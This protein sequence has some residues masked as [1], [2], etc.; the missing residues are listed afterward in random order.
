MS[1]GE[2]VALPDGCGPVRSPAG[3][4][5]GRLARRAANVAAALAVAAGLWIGLGM[6]E[7]PLRSDNVRGA[8]W[9]WAPAIP[10]SP[11]RAQALTDPVWQFAPWFEFAR[12]ELAAGRV[13]LWNPHQDGGV[14]FLANPMTS[15]ASPLVW[16]ILLLGVDDGWNPSLLARLLL[17]LLGTW[18]WLRESG[19][20][21]PAAAVGAAIFALSGPFVV[22][23]ANPNVLAVAPAPLLLLFVQRFAATGR[24]SDAAGIAVATFLI[25]AGG[26]PESVAAVAV[27]AGA[28]LLASSGSWRRR[29]TAAG[30]ALLGFALA[31]P[32]WAPFLEY[33]ALSE[34]RAGAGR[35]NF[36]LPV[37]ALVRLL[38]PGG[39]E[40]FPVESVAFVSAGALLLAV[41]GASAWRT[42]RT[43]AASVGVAVLVLATA[44]AT[45]VGVALARHT[46]VYWSRFLIVLPLAIA[47]LAALGLD[48][49][50]ALAGIRWRPAA[51]SVASWSIAVL[52]A[53][54]LLTAARGVHAVSR[55]EHR[56]RSTPLLEILAADRDLYRILPLHT[57]LPPN[58]A[59]RLGLDDVRGYDA[60]AP[61][62]WRRERA[63]IGRFSG[64]RSVS[65]VLEPWELSRGG[66][67]LDRWNVK[68]L[69]L[70]PQLPYDA[71]TFRRDFD[72]DLE[73]VY[74][75]PDGVVFRNRRCLPRVRLEGGG[76]SVRVAGRTPTRWTIEVEATGADRLVV[77]NPYF[78]GWQAKVDGRGVR[79]DARPGQAVAVPLT[80]GRHRVEVVYR[81]ASLKLGILMAL[82]GAAALLAACARRV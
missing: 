50:Q 65:D 9:P 15:L 13:P 53:A 74:R 69:L 39:A 61:A 71:D 28:W 1:E 68:Y 72:L 77:A 76:G 66:T 52:V 3:A 64:T 35:A 43:V 10:P 75:G 37:A 57:F 20:S 22:W 47:P 48:R 26:H 24:R 8:V 40:G 27:L 51:R 55:P 2:E 5:A 4:P 79:L 60:L 81:P 54:N 6:A 59:T 41:A 11:L 33:Y 34:A 67:A 58:E 49:L 45:P 16:P 78:A 17:G 29:V 56:P 82:A 70:H 14:P 19:R 12:R 46:H 23:L 18:W 25:V 38:R 44:Y 7:G 42:S 21:R 63:A 30:A 62:A 31:A 73:E 80:A 32:L 36:A